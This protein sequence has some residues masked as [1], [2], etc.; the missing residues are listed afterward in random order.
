[1]EKGEGRGRKRHKSGTGHERTRTRRRG[2]HRRERK[3]TTQ[4]EEIQKRIIQKE[5]VV[6]KPSQI[7]SVY[8]L[9]PKNTD[10]LFDGFMKK[11]NGCSITEEQEK[12]FRYS[13]IKGQNGKPI[14]CYH[15]TNET[16]YSFDVSHL[17]EGG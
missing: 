17:G 4:Q 14:V 1:M 15:S 2:K 8:N 13:K 11:E 16:F 10:S 6:F 7:K 3:K 12:Y 5:I 9:K